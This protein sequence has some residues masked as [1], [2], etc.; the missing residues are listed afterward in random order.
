MTIGHGEGANRPWLQELPDTMTSVVWG[1]WLE[2]NPMT[3]Q[4]LGIQQ[5]DLVRVTSPVG[6]LDTPAVLYPGIRPDVVAMPLG[7]GHSGYGRYA[8]GRGVNP[9][10]LLLPALDSVTGIVASG[11]TRVRIERTGIKGRL[12]TVEHPAMEQSDL[13][14]IKRR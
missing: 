1:S 7:Q 14:T 8:R 10:T 3:A 9:L 13:I 2:V 12:V 5:G 6:S 4:E 11:A